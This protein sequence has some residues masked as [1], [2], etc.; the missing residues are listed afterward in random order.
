[1]TGPLKRRFARQKNFLRARF[2]PEGYL[3]LHFTI[4]LCV[5][6]AAGW[7]FAT[8]AEDVTH[9]DPIVQTDL[10]IASWFHERTTPARVT[11]A[12]AV[13][14]CGSPG[15]VTVATLAAVALLFWRRYFNRAITLAATML[16]GSVLIICLKHLF[17]RHRPVFENPIVTLNSYGFP[18][19]HTMGATIFY[20]VLALTAA[21]FIA[22]WRW[23]A[24]V[25]VVA[26]IMVLLIGLTRIYLGAH[27]FSDV[28]AAI[29]A[30][31]AWLTFCWTGSESLR[32]RRALRQLR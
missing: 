11:A 30:G 15:F 26:A 17:H 21:T 24:A 29:T 14:F 20:G 4:G 10:A 12:R 3:G 18:S 13:S 32:R 23:R 6:L 5:I 1:M 19:G 31:I 16:G 8:L 28:L 2:S 22:R 27:Y 9:N 25:C 7:Y